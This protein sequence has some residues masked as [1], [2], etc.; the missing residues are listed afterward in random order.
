MINPKVIDLYH[1][2]AEPDFKQAWD[3]GIRG[4]IHKASEGLGTDPKYHERRNKCLIEA[5]YMLWG[6][7]H[8]ARPGDVAL[9]IQHFLSVVAPGASIP[10]AFDKS[11]VLVLDHEDPRVPLWFA[12]GWLRGVERLT[13]K[14]PWLYSGFLIRE[15]EENRHAPEFSEYPLW[16]AEYGPVAKVPQPWK[17]CILHQYTDG[18]AGPEPHII[19]GMPGGLDISSFDG[20][21]EDLE[22]IWFA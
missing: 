19:K 9:Q 17:T 5:P 22:K 14:T 3:A 11:I 21:D 12:A 4:V 2:D 16:L 6:A 1:G 20:S 7:Y 15:Q 13:G 10:A 8:F 18:H